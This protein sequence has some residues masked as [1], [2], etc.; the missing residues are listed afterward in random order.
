MQTFASNKMSLY[1]LVEPFF[2]GAKY[3]V[4]LLN[5]TALIK[6]EIYSGKFMA[7]TLCLG[8][9]LFTLVSSFTSIT[10]AMMTHFTKSER[11]R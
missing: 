7:N 10:F 1:K 8:L 11:F 3:R 9:L 5:L 2:G 4:Y 6:R